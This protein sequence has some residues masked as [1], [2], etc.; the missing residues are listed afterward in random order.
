MKMSTSKLSTRRLVKF[1][2]FVAKKQCAAP[3]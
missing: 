2:K 3:K 1:V